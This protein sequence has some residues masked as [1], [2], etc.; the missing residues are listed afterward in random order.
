MENQKPNEC[1]YCGESL[2]AKRPTAKWCS[3]RCRSA[4]RYA[5]DP[6]KFNES[7]RAYK[8]RMAGAAATFHVMNVMLQLKEANDGVLNQIEGRE[9]KGPTE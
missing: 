1:R 9:D 2:K 8:N 5:E 7:S 4:A 3:E 6:Y